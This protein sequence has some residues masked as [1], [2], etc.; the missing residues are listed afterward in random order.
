MG[1][2]YEPSFYHVICIKCFAKCINSVI[3]NVVYA[4]HF[5]LD[6]D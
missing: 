3:I 2:S 4:N 1:G 5:N 6:D